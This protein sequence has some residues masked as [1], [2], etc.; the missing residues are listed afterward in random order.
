[1][2]LVCVCGG[3][4]AGSRECNIPFPSMAMAATSD[5]RHPTTAPPILETPCLAA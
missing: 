1:M 2:G 5:V 4:C 3:W